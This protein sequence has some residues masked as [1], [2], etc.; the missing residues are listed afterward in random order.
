MALSKAEMKHQ[1]N[2]STKAIIKDLVTNP[3]VVA[4]GLYLAIEALNKNKGWFN[5]IKETGVEAAIF[6]T[7]VIIAMA[8][9][10]AINEMIKG[11]TETTKNVAG[12][13]PLLAAAA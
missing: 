9:S 10:G 5:E 12:L 8:K 2:E 11:A 1:A 6:A 13:L 3:M 4:V 7:P